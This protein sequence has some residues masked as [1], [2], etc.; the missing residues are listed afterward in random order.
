V[1]GDTTDGQG[2][3]VPGSTLTLARPL[4]EWTAIWDSW[5]VPTAD[6]EIATYCPGSTPPPPVS[7]HQDFGK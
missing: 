6:K 4:L 1:S 2:L 3:G 5:L 7:C